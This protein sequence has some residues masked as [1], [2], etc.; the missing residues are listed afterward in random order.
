MEI[1]PPSPSHTRNLLTLLFSFFV[2]N[3][4][5]QNNHQQC[6][7][8]SFFISVNLSLTFELVRILIFIIFNLYSFTEVSCIYH[9]LS[10]IVLSQCSVVLVYS[11]PENKSAV[12]L[13][14]YLPK[15]YTNVRLPSPQSLTLLLK[16]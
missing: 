5:V 9:M 12:V 1:V 13:V 8:L 11:L 16:L 7:A 4:I 3:V 2:L 10:P 6:N 14:Y 15:R